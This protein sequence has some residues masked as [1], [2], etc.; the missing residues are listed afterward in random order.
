MGMPDA[1]FKFAMRYCSGMLRTYRAL[2]NTTCK[3]GAQNTRSRGIS[4]DGGETNFINYVKVWYRTISKT[5]FV[6]GFLRYN[7]LMLKSWNT[8][9]PNTN[10]AFKKDVRCLLSFIWSNK[11]KVSMDCIKVAF[12]SFNS[13]IRHSVP[14]ANNYNILCRLWN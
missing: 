1:V 14:T 2:V 10:A 4:T 12:R 6:I 9:R 3:S 7:F 13:F 11:V 5:E 8:G